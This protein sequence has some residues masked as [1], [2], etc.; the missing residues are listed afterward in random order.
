MERRWLKAELHSHC[1]QDPADYRICRYSPEQ[2]ISNAA[3]LGYEILA[4]TCHNSDVWTESLSDYARNLGITLIP[5]MEVAAEPTR[6]ILVYNFHTSAEN[7]N[8][9]KK[10]RDRSRED[11]LVIA[12]HAF[13]PGSVCLRGRLE[14]NLRIFDA[15]EYSGFQVRGLDF[16]RRSVELAAE[17][18]KPLVGCGDIHYLWQLDRTFTW[19]YAK[20]DV[21]S[22]LSA[23]KQGLVRIQTSPLSWLEAADWWA[24]TL[25]RYVFPVNPAPSKHALGTLF[26]ASRRDSRKNRFAFRNEPLDEIEDGRCLGTAQKS[27][28][29]QRIHISHQG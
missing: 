21:Q 27:V 8:T 26:P 9:L 13:F 3:K 7:L 2:M 11:T 4:I 15:I 24:T 20:P 16:N 1:S 6:H 14:Q 19:I 22:V 23:V 5:G 17:A 12:P 10:I 28:K 18:G 25:W 29:S